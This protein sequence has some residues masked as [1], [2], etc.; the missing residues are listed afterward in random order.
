MALLEVQN[1]QTHF[2]TI[3][4]VSAAD[5]SDGDGFTNAQE[6]ALGTDPTDP[7]SRFAVV[8]FT[9]TSTGAQITWT[10]VPGKI[11][12]LETKSSLSDGPWDASGE[13][14]VAGPQQD[15]MTAAMDFAGDLRFARVALVAEDSSR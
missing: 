13:P 2:G 9:R 1:L 8:S 3:D 15:Q 14:V 6:H 4:G 5:D 11:Y 7:S 10:S 12:Q